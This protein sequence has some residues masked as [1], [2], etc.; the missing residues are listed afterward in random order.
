MKLGKDNVIIGSVP[1]DLEIGDGNVIVGATDV[2]GNT[3]I[4]TPMAVGRDAQAGPNSIAIGADAKAG[5]AVTLGEALHQLTCIAEAAQDRESATLLAQI[6]TELKKT[7]PD[8]T[9]ILRAWDGVKAAASIAGAHSLI[10]AI[11][12]FLLLL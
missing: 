7:E 5:S 10:Q 11:T 9:V 1:S 8:K 12:T 6:D 4:N 3:M 2:N